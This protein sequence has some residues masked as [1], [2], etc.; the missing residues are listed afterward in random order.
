[1]RALAL[2]FAILLLF[3]ATV[4]AGSAAGAFAKDSPIVAET[5][6]KA[7]AEISGKNIY[8]C[9][10]KI[11]SEPPY[12]YRLMNT[13]THD[14]FVQRYAK[15]FSTM[16]P[17]LKDQV[18]HFTQG[19]SNPGQVGGQALPDGGDNIIGVLPG[20]D[21][22]KWIVLGGHYDTREATVGGAAIDDTSG[23]CTVKEIA[24]AFL[25]FN[26]Q[27]EVT[28]VF[29]WWDGEEWGLFGSR[30]F[31]K[32]HNATKELLGLAAD[33]KVEILMGHSYDIVGINY[34][35]YNTWV[36]YGERTEVL[37]YAIL[38]LRTPPLVAENFTLRDYSGVPG[39]DDFDEVVLP[40]FAQYNALAKEVA[41]GLLQLPPQWVQ[42]RDD[43]YGRSDH[44][45]FTAA[46]IP[47]MRIQGSHD[48]EWRDYHQPT[49]TLAAAAVTAGGIDKLQAGFDTAA[50]TGGLTA[51]YAA[52]TGGLG[53]YAN[54]GTVDP[55]ALDANVTTVACPE[56]GVAGDKVPAVSLLGASVAS[57]AALAL[58]R[59]RTR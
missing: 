13:P 34:P 31:V 48:N 45:P 17:R 44:V 43:Q 39:R 22:H 11:T 50:G 52:I 59:R 12:S 35:A 49:D 1:M 51:I 4:Q 20:K 2:A 47:G 58:I 27:P 54:L 21:L 5:L 9:I 16:N 6:T 55:C 24:R 41:L 53:D 15:V 30:A 3:A 7:N 36:N 40:R 19:G 46:G 38:N 56:L 10:D 57:A 14:Q 23:I 33:A 42:V 18:V 29:A 37:E 25:T 32:D 28:M 26:R 8:D